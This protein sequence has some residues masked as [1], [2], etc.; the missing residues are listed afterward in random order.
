MKRQFAVLCVDDD[1]NILRALQR[2]LIHEEYDAYF[3]KSAEDALCLL[4]EK[5]IAVILSDMKL[6][7]MDGLELLRIIK[8][9]WPLTVRVIVSGFLQVPQLMAAINNAEVFRFISKPWIAKEEILEVIKN[10][11]DKYT[12]LE[13]TDRVKGTLKARNNTYQNIIKRTNHELDSAKHS[14]TLASLAG[15]NI[16]RVLN[17]Q[18]QNEKNT[19]IIKELI[20]K[21]SNIYESMTALMAL[22]FQIIEMREFME[23]FAGSLKMYEGIKRVEI[24]N[25]PDFGV[26]LHIKD[27][28]LEFAIAN[29]IDNML[30]GI[31]KYV[32]ILYQ[33]NEVKAKNSIV[34]AVA[35]INREESSSDKVKTHV[36]VIMIGFLK[37]VV[38]SFSGSFEIINK[39]TKFL[40][41]IELPGYI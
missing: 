41:R 5:D 34:F 20:S 17:S 19:D 32:K 6:P 10:S 13:D 8:Q 1:E 36:Q 33:H 7:G 28:L 3:A 30:P 35:P 37:T 4:E 24:E 31:K 15:R 11:I 22:D 27:T 2:I 25:L 14:T 21:V 12:E 18:I 23:K 39:G 9:R 40:V 16:L 26:K 29:F 38:E